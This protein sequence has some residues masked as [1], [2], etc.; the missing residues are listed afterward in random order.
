MKLN[1][2]ILENFLAN[3]KTITVY[4][5]NKLTYLLKYGIII[6]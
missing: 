4:E 2:I 1:L 6:L 5:Q 3:A